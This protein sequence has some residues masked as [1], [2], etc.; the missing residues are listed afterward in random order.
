MNANLE[1]LP[2]ISICFSGNSAKIQDIW[3]IDTVVKN[4]QNTA[5]PQ[6]HEKIWYLAAQDTGIKANKKALD[7]AKSQLQGI[8]WQGHFSYRNNDPASFLSPSQALWLDIDNKNPDM[9]WHTTE[10]KQ[11]IWE[12]ELNP[13][14]ISLHTS[15]SRKGLHLVCRYSWQTVEEFYSAHAQLAWQLEYI[16]G[17][18]ADP[19]ST[20]FS[21]QAYLSF[22][23]D[24]F[25][26]PFSESYDFIPADNTPE[27]KPFTGKK[28]RQKRKSVKSTSKEKT[29]EN[30]DNTP[31]EYPPAKITYT[32]LEDLWQKLFSYCRQN[33]IPI[34]DS[35]NDRITF[36]FG[37]L[38]A[39]QNNLAQVKPVFLEYCTL[40][41]RWKPEKEPDRL[42]TLED[43]HKR[44]DP[45]RK[46]KASIFSIID[47][48][49]AYN[50]EL[51]KDNIPPLNLINIPSE[52]EYCSDHLADIMQFIQNNRV[53][54]IW[55]GAGHGKTTAVK[56][57]IQAL[58][59]PESFNILPNCLL[60][61]TVVIAKQFANEHKDTDFKVGH[62]EGGDDILDIQAC[63]HT[64]LAVIS[65]SGF[66]K[67]IPEHVKFDTLIIDESHLIS[68][69]YNESYRLEE[70]ENILKS[71]SRCN[72]FI[73]LTA[74]PNI[75]FLRL[76]GIPT[77]HIIF[78]PKQYFS[79]RTV[80]Y[81]YFSDLGTEIKGTTAQHT[82]NNK[83]VIVF[84]N[85]KQ[86]NNTLAEL[87]KT[88]GI[89]AIAIDSN[90]KDSPEYRKI[91]QDQIITADVLFST[92]ILQVGANINNLDIGAVFV[93]IN[94][95]GITAGD[96]IQ[97]VNRIRRQT[98]LEVVLCTT[99]ERNEVKYEITENSILQGLLLK[100]QI[101]KRIYE[102]NPIAFTEGCEKQY[103][104]EID[105]YLLHPNGTENHN[106]VAYWVNKKKE[107]YY[108]LPDIKNEI[109][110]WDERFVFIE[111]LKEY[112]DTKPIRILPKTDAWENAINH[113]Q[114]N[115]ESVALFCVL[116]LRVSATEYRQLY[117]VDKKHIPTEYY[118][119]APDLA[120]INNSL[121]SGSLAGILSRYQELKGYTLTHEKICY[122]LANTESQN[123]YKKL[124]TFLAVM[125]FRENQKAHNQSEAQNLTKIC[126]ILDAINTEFIIHEE[127]ERLRVLFKCKG[128]TLL[129]FNIFNFGQIIRA[130]CLAESKQANK[131]NSTGKR[132]T[133]IEIKIQQK[134][135]NILAV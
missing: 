33:S 128:K 61:P 36:G 133:I 98:K 94:R 17:I 66:A 18:A 57:I 93:I 102:N 38:D 79:T 4:I 16:T 32:D 124:K 37:L 6:L 78:K 67:K 23:P 126:R 72:R 44:Y 34:A 7:Q 74:T 123:D 29:A 46:G 47:I 69:D 114:E 75:P 20:V 120:G 91:I 81:K 41:E 118:S 71:Q 135:A 97:Y 62:V 77:L 82:P 3:D 106:G 52:K 73:Y 50:I 86:K 121:K 35:Y 89:Q 5:N 55:A 96:I 15:A 131:L 25:Y 49:R 100:Q 68:N 105:R 99:K 30:K 19:A 21:Q 109:S 101:L 1:H 80:I 31:R 127:F 113:V 13:C 84:N 9:P 27:F 119:L 90:K 132:S 2:L 107:S 43:L 12:S 83:K 24:L 56:Q 39:Y 115:I 51:E 108:R 129:G 48:L 95:H 110:T 26:R 28:R 92:C 87:L 117:G 53:C 59:P 112:S 64:D 14:I 45:N 54:C 125:N 8:I 22:D 10:V 116:N 134:Y 85:S 111:D 65:W 40:Y 88:E 11:R 42:A 76:F 60:V 63:L 130:C 103:I 104:N 70:I 58:N 122:F